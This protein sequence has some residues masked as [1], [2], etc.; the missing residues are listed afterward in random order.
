MEKSEKKIRPTCQSLSQS[1]L[2]L[3]PFETEQKTTATHFRIHPGCALLDVNFTMLLKWSYKNGSDKAVSKGGNRT[4]HL[5]GVA[6][7]PV[8]ICPRH[9]FK[10]EA[11]YLRQQSQVNAKHRFD[12]K[13]VASNFRPWKV[14]LCPAFAPCRFEFRAVLLSQLSHFFLSFRV[15]VLVVRNGAFSALGKKSKTVGFICTKEEI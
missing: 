4:S 11:R 7:K 3:K 2:L 5:N 13:S 8:D 1:Y 12:L 9:W 10:D 6:K 14:L 15:L